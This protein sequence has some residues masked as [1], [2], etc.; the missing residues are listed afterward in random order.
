M[1]DAAFNE[2]QKI[3]FAKHLFDGVTETFSYEIKM[4]VQRKS[5]GVAG[6]VSE[7]IRAVCHNGKKIN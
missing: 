2:I 5:A 1:A 7:Q 3:G 6:G 4:R